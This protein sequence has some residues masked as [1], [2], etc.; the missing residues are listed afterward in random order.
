MCTAKAI[1]RVPVPD[2]CCLWAETPAAPMNIALIGIFDG[3]AL[4]GPGGLVRI[5]VIRSFIAARLDRAPMLRRV[6]LP[7]RPGQ[8]RMAWIDAP[9]FGIGAGVHRRGRVRGLVRAPVG[10]PA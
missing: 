8:G 5:A 2:L 9:H 1:T 4:T 7:T 10:D 6:L 3:G